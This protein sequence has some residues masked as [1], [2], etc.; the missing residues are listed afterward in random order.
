[1]AEQSTRVFEHLESRVES[2]KKAL[3][4]YA[5]ICRASHDGGNSRQTV[6]ASMTDD[7]II[8]YVKGVEMLHVNES[9]AEV[10]TSPKGVRKVL[11]GTNTLSGFE[12]PEYLELRAKRRELNR[13]IIGKIIG[14]N[15]PSQ[16]DPTNILD[17]A[18]ITS[19]DEAQRFIFREDIEPEMLE[20]I[21]AYV[22]ADYMVTDIRKTMYPDT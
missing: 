6:R 7:Q 14:T 15:D 20:M 22:L 19:I 9:P 21:G 12:T 8:T 5:E 2:A 11:I 3:D 18:K 17:D 13:E 10:K 16:Y 4:Y 1:M